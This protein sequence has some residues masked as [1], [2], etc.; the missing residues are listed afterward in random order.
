MAIQV[1]FG[2]WENR[3]LGFGY[4]VDWGGKVFCAAAEI[5][6]EEMGGEDSGF[7]E[8]AGGISR[9]REVIDKG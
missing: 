8:E 9:A 3:F 1:R 4:V 6:E 2:T 7:E 5:E